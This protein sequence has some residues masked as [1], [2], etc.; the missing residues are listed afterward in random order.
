MIEELGGKPTRLLK[1]A[2]VWR[3]CRFQVLGSFGW[4]P[5]GGLACLDIGF[6]IYGFGFCN[7]KFAVPSVA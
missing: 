7:V 1:L 5:F 2:S 6:R 4:V 3:G